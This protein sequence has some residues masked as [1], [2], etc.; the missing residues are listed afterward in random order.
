MYP[1]EQGLA[2]SLIPIEV[3]EHENRLSRRRGSG[4]S[5]GPGSLA[6][7][8]S[9]ILAV[10][11]ILLLFPQERLQA[12]EVEHIIY[13]APGGKDEN[14]GLDRDAPILTLQRAQKIA[15]QLALTRPAD[16]RVEVAKGRYHAQTVKWTLY[17]PGHRIRI[18]GNPAR[19]GDA[20]F[21]GGNLGLTFLTMPI[22]GGKR[23]RL[24]ISGITITRYA[25]AIILRGG[26][27]DPGDFNGSNRIAHNVFLDNGGTAYGRPISVTSIV[28]LVNSRE[29]I[30]ENNV[31]D[32]MY[33]K[34]CILLHAI[35]LAHYSSNNAIRGNIFRRG[36]GDPIRIRDSSNDNRITDN[37]FRDVGWRGAITEWF[38]SNQRKCRKRPPECPSKGTVSSGNTVVSGHLGRKIA[39]LY[40]FVREASASCR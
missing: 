39:E 28:G 8:L 33:A 24:E 3:R 10:L 18:V 34:D 7:R 27:T 26:R 15:A 29:N 36:C 20:V 13:V 30:I 38:C 9:R 17:V 23:T 1:E 25:T 32:G 31:F 12:G 35:Y 21:D 2:H 4:S 37:Q 5:G 11:A 40:T 22:G 14:S 6:A 16:I 19:P